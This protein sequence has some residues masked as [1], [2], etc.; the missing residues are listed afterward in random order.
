VQG[1]FTQAGVYTAGWEAYEELLD[2]IVV[3]EDANL[4]ERVGV[5]QHGN[6]VHIARVFIPHAVKS[7]ERRVGGSAND[8]HGV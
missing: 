2:T 5:G 7:I 8:G 6:G 4:V 1:R 3:L